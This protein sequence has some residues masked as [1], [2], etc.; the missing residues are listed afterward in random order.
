MASPIS[1]CCS[2][3][4]KS[5]KLFGGEQRPGQ[6]Q[7]RPPP[8]QQRPK[9]RGAEA[10]RRQRTEKAREPLPRLSAG[11]QAQKRGGDTPPVERRRG[12]E[13]KERERQAEP[14]AQK[15]HLVRQMRA[16][17]GS[18]P[19]VAQPGRGPRRSGQQLLGGAAGGGVVDAQARQLRPQRRGAHAQKAQREQM[20]QLVQQ[21]RRKEREQK[22]RLRDVD[23]ECEGEQ[24]FGAD[25]QQ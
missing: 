10:E 2:T 17:A 3:A 4:A 21:H 5:S 12:Q 8:A 16:E 24:R 7:R 1:A 13:I 23:E 22:A 9:S 15:E 19:G 25:A 18:E 20:P 14:R 6:E 11:P